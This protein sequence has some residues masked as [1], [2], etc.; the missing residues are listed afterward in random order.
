MTWRLYVTEPG[1]GQLEVF[2]SSENGTLTIQWDTNGIF[3]LD[4]AP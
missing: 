3:Y 1:S 4:L 2:D